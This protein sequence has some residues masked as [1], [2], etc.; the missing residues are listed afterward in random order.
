V[1]NGEG[2]N[3]EG[4]GFYVNGVEGNLVKI[5][6]SLTSHSEAVSHLTSPLYR[7][8]DVEFTKSLHSERRIPVDILFRETEDGFELSYQ[9][10]NGKCLN[11]KW[12]YPHEL[13][14]NAD[15]ALETIKAQLAKLGDTPYVAREIH[16][17]SAPYFIPISILNHWRRDTLN[18]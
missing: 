14:R 10:V 17:E 11:G 12:I 4:L 7:N 15:K 8:L 6:K 1:A 5:N 16:I 9:I 2:T 18:E 3:G 13:A